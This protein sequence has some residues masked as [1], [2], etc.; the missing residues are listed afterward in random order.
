MQGKLWQA[1]AEHQKA[2]ECY[3]EAL[4]LNPFMWDAFTALCDLGEDMTQSSV[5]RLMNNRQQCLDTQCL[6]NDPGDGE[7]HVRAVTWS[8]A[9]GGTGRVPTERIITLKY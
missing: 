5:I 3:A 6:Q 2:T 1:H 7:R 9:A 4:K 8:N